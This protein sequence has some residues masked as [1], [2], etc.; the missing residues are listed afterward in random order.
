MNNNDNRHV[1]IFFLRI[2][3]FSTLDCYSRWYERDSV[4]LQLIRF[5]RFIQNSFG[6]T[7]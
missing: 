2:K 6:D 5:C 7:N 3:L 1:Q 4:I